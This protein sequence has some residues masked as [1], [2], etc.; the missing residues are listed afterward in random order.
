[1]TGAQPDRSGQQPARSAKPCEVCVHVEWRMLGPGATN[2]TP[3]MTAVS[4]TVH[5]L[6]HGGLTLWTMQVAAGPWSAGASE[7]LAAPQPGAKRKMEYV[8]SHWPQCCRFCRHVADRT[9][10]EGP[11]YLDSCQRAEAMCASSGTPRHQPMAE[12]AVA[13]GCGPDGGQRHQ[14][15]G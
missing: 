9:L 11:L 13:R 2:S 8:S 6:C 4:P 3:L 15:L 12:S 5:W 1:M 14:R 10:A 7:C